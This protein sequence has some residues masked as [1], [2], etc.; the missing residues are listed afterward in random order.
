[1]KK[2]QYLSNSLAK[3]CSAYWLISFSMAIAVFYSISAS[4]QENISGYQITSLVSGVIKQVYVQ[5]GK[6]V[7]QGDL[8][9]E[10]DTTL[11]DSNL[12]EAKA[13]ISLAKINFSEAKKERERAEE[14]YE[15]T[16]L[17]EHELQL[18][19]VLYTKASAQYAGAKNKLIH[20]QWEK[21][22][23]KLYAPFN[24]RISKVSAYAGQYVN[25]QFIAQTL[26]VLEK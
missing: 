23:S 5:A 19:R 18:A 17:S 13:M 24:A 26:V 4:A 12:A 16:V 1:M 7:K 11:I 2:Q 3:K 6:T 14:L 10:F 20:A 25:N 15:R 8:I 21:T 9:L 22:H